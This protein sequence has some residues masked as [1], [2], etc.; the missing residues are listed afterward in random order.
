MPKWKR[1]V[2]FS[3][4]SRRELDQ[5]LPR[6]GEDEEP[7]NLADQTLL[8]ETIS[9]GIQELSSPRTRAFLALRF[10]LLGCGSHSLDELE[11]ILRCSRN[12]ISACYHAAVRRLRNRLL[13][14]CPSLAELADDSFPHRWE[15]Y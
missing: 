2:L 11:T 12:Y 3:D 4:L 14:N 10:G 15:R 9:R 7:P 8:A 5:V 1:I 6:T 13:L